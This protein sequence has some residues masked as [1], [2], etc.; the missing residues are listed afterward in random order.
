MSSRALCGSFSKTSRSSSPE[1]QTPAEVS[2]F[3]GT[4]GRC[5][6][7]QTAPETDD[8]DHVEEPE[9][10][11]TGRRSQLTPTDQALVRFLTKAGVTPAEIH[12]E[13][14]WTLSAIRHHRKKTVNDAGYITPQ[15]HK[16]LQKIE[17]ANKRTNHKHGR[18][19]PRTASKPLIAP[20][21]RP[22]T[23]RL[24][25]EPTSDETVDNQLRTP[26]APAATQDFLSP[27]V[28]SAGLDPGTE[29]LLKNTGF[30]SVEKLRA[31]AKLG[32][33][34]IQEFVGTEVAEMSPVDKTLLVAALITA[35]TKSSPFT[36][37][38][39]SPTTNKTHSA[40]EP[41]VPSPKNA[42]V[43]APKR[44]YIEIEDSES[45]EAARGATFPKKARAD[46][47]KRE[48]IEIEESE[49]ESDGTPRH[50]TPYEHCYSVSSKELTRTDQALIRFLLKKKVTR[51]EIHEHC[52]W[53][54]STISRHKNRTSSHDKPYIS[55]RF[56][57]ILREI[58]D[59]RKQTQHSKAISRL[60]NTGEQSTSAHKVDNGPRIGD[61]KDKVIPATHDED[62]LSRF[63][64]TAGLDTGSEEALKQAGFTSIKK[65]RCVANIG[66]ENIREFVDIQFTAMSGVERVLLITA[67]VRVAN[68]PPV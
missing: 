17:K 4:D 61:R 48:Y 67:L 15:F 25:R 47:P 60:E 34:E 58:K 65:L 8:T 38:P 35:S 37:A 45:D 33:E 46:S 13:C 44:E 56:G 29:E 14:G 5:P 3:E 32:K 39:S 54:K 68:E 63:V 50:G 52:G 10:P 22:S 20:Q 19:R 40:S 66:R 21:T 1:I 26:L 24:G 9:T 62:F 53:A 30:T 27:F 49:S 64:T 43:L 23:R 6:N 11:R 59:A 18:G 28:I 31:M 42:S 7:L 36:G 16:I 12:A 57:Q 55:A 41:V 51:T 2:A